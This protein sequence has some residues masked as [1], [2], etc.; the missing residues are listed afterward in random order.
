M[1]ILFFKFL[2]NFQYNNLIFFQYLEE[3]DKKRE[4]RK[5]QTILC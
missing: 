3:P 5:K 1:V 2:V 4:I